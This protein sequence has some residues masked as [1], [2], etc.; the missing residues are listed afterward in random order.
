M[1]RIVRWHIRGMILAAFMMLPNISTY[2]QDHEESIL[3]RANMLRWATLTPDIGIEWQLNK[4]WSVLGNATYTRWSWKDNNRRFAQKEFAGEIRHYMGYMTT[5]RPWY[6][7][8]MVH[9]GQFN[10]GLS[11]NG[12][13]GDYM[14]GGITAGYRLR[15]HNK[16][17]YIDFGG[18]FG[19]THASIEKYKTI[20]GVRYKTEDDNSNYIGIN[21]LSVAIVWKFLNKTKP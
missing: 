7:G 14:G 17:F 18:A 16:R 12:R 15:L 11:D 3:L 2:A 4:E 19:F 21:K 5:Q 13:Q 6:A 1:D 10:F 9:G 20:E 8:L